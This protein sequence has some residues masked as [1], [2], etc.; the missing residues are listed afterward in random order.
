[1]FDEEED[2][3]PVDDE[4]DNLP[5]ITRRMRILSTLQKTC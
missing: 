4:G 5:R 1:M 2:V 3:T